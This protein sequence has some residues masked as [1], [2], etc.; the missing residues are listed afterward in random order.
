MVNV[1]TLIGKWLAWKVGRGNKVRIEENPWIG[2]MGNY[3]L[4]GLL[5]EVLHDSGIF[6]LEDAASQ[7]ETE[8]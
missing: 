4:S 8:D 1:F 7:T 2:C 6:S 3:R 5:L